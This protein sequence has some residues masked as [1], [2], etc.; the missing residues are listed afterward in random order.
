MANHPLGSVQTL[1][2]TAPLPAT[3]P[4]GGNLHGLQG[5]LW[6]M[7]GTIVDTEPYWIRAE[8]DL[9]E[10]HGGTWSTEQA[11]ALVGQALDFSAGLLQEAGVDLG[12]RSIIEH[13]TGRVAAAVAQAVP[14]RPG[15][16]ELLADLRRR[17]VPCAMVTMSEPL[18]ATAVASRLPEGTFSHLVTGDRV[19]S[20]KPDP[21]AYQLG[22]DL[23]ASEVPGLRKDRVI[24]IEDSLPGVTSALGAG[25]VT[26]AVP[27]FVALPAD[28]RRTDW[29]TL[30]G[31]T[32]LDLAALLERRA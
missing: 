9:V 5:V 3:D 2:R 17:E 1:A 13:L 25:L 10:E 11:T 15:A 27:H 21:E 19:R 32:A 24:A 29:E 20:G 12:I 4:T 8:K 23:L 6:D 18:L 31:R 14:W 30:Q 28:E 26:L 22:F 16:R 7:D